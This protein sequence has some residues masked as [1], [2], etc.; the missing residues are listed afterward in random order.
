MKL[1]RQAADT[2]HETSVLVLHDINFAHCYLDYIVSIRD[3]AVIRQGSPCG[4]M[5]REAIRE[6]YDMC[7]EIWETQ[8]RRI[9]IYHT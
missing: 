1:L 8:E 2:L 9:S 6:V 3:G 5:T 4:I 7:V